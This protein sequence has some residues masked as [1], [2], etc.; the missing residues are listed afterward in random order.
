MFLFDNLL[1]SGILLQT[2]YCGWG[3]RALEAIE[4]DD[5]VIEFVGEGIRYSLFGLL[6]HF[7]VI[8]SDHCFFLLM[9]L[10]TILSKDFTYVKP[11]KLLS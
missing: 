4:K 11:V 10:W 7:I 2:Q 6:R 8:Y 9:L 5:F 1:I 3:S